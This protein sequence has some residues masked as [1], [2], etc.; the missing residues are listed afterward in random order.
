MLSRQ[1][2]GPGA[3]SPCNAKAHSVFVLDLNWLP[4]SVALF[5][6][7]SV[8]RARHG[9]F[10][11]VTPNLLLNLNSTLP[12]NHSSRIT[13]LRK[14]CRS[15]LLLPLC[16][17]ACALTLPGPIELMAQRFGGPGGG[18]G[19]NSP[20][21][22][23]KRLPRIPYFGPATSVPLKEVRIAGQRGVPEAKIR[24]L[25]ETRIHR[26]YD[27]EQ[28][29]KDVRTLYG[30]GLFRDVRTYNREVDGGIA[31]TFEVFERPLIQHIRFTGNDKVKDKTLL[32]ESG[33]KVGDALHRFGVEEARRTLEQFYNS[34]GYNEAKVSIVEGT[35][36][37]SRGIVF[38]I[39][40]GVILR[41]S[42]TKFEGNTIA[43]DARLRTVVQSKPG[44]LWYF[45]GKTSEE[46]IDQDIERLTGYYRNLGFFRARIK[47]EPSRSESGKWTDVNFIIDEG[48]RYRV[49]NIQINGNMRFEDAE[50]RA[51]MSL[52]EGEFVNLGRMRADLTSARDYYGSQGYIFADVNVNPTY[53]PEPGELDLV[54]NIT[55]GD[56]YLVGRIIVN[57]EGDHAHTRRS[58]VLNRL[59]FKTGDVIDIRKIRN[60]ERRLRASQLFLHNPAQGAT[61][62]IVVKP[63][64]P[65]GPRI[66]R[67]PSSSAQGS[68]S[69]GQSPEKTFPQR[70][71]Q[72]VIELQKVRRREDAEK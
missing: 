16:I 28:V 49:R 67:Q 64:D 55:E 14:T 35:D 11:V 10:G 37:D 12:V 23:E 43:S 54:Y 38:E 25:L 31:V 21:E 29:Q 8:C 57:I 5:S 2:V 36:A 68:T 59:S 65:N 48:P 71:K 39:S 3:N 52:A 13:S 56:Q 69:R 63:P 22:D 19:S 42:K 17:V 60:S 4:T 45:G 34:K 53:L 70:V 58:V 20:G 24:S 51:Q 62:R 9:L 27:P 50:L 32:K 1:A 44:I 26:S 18:Q 66:A 7:T 40:E 61:P 46:Q 72:Y 41:V 33:L 6:A 47:V 15:T 30:T